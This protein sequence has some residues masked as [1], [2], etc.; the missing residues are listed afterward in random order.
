MLKIT[1]L[2]CCMLMASAAVIVSQ[3]SAAE[4]SQQLYAKA[5]KEG[6]VVWYAS[7]PRTDVAERIGRAFE[8][9]YKGIKAVVVRTTAQTIF[10]RLTMDLRS[11]HPIADVFTTSDAGHIVELKRQ[12]MLQQWIPPNANNMMAAFRK[13]N[14]KEGYA[15][16]PFGGVIGITYNTKFVSK[17]EAPKDWPDLLETKWKNRIAIGHPGF[18]GY[19]GTW[20]VQMTQMYGWTFFEKLNKLNPQVGRS[21]TDTVTMLNSGE[22]WIGVSNLAAG[23]ESAQKGN[24]IGIVYPKS[25]TILMTT[26]T[27]LM[28]N[29][30][31]PNAGKLFMNWLL[32]SEAQQIIADSGYEH[33]IKNGVKTKPGAISLENV[34]TVRPTSE[35]IVKG[36]PEVK[37]KF[38]DTFGI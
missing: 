25:G 34:V 37:D 14:D 22:R 23:I 36:I 24:P 20:A 4:T 5:K 31:H 9:H 28:K 10:Q 27:G 19:A 2:L 32:T 6:T 29:A 3:A 8:A 17:E 35:E 38:R 26:P 16:T 7:S 11:N 30:P 18:S 13:Y 12:K 15:Y 21:I 33:V 1:Q